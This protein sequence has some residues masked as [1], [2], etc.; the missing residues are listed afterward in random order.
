M[1]LIN[2]V[3]QFMFLLRTSCYYNFNYLQEKRE[4]L[5]EEVNGVVQASDTIQEELSVLSNGK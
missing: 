4:K 5:S 2:P 1:V 3:A